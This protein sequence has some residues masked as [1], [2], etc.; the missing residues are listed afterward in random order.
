ML[1]RGVAVSDPRKPQRIIGC[2]VALAAAVPTLRFD[3]LTKLPPIQ[4]EGFG[5]HLSHKP[6][7]MLLRSWKGS[8]Y[9]D[10]SMALELQQRKTSGL[11][12]LLP[13]VRKTIALYLQGP[14]PP[15]N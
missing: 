4:P 1:T 2:R 5:T 8:L 10:W 14:S 12:G 9:R 13:A 11:R 6:V 7:A 3:Q 15:V